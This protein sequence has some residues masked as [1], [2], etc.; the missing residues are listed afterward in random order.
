MTG[1]LVVLVS[2]VPEQD[3]AR[4]RAAAPDADVTFAARPADLADRIPGA[5]VVAGN[6]D[7]ASFGRASALRWVHSWAAG[8]DG[9]L[10]PELVASPVVLTSSKGNGAV[11][12]AEH[13]LM[14]ML[15]LDRDAPRWMRAQESRTWDRFG[16]GELNGATCGIV[17]MGG[18]GS[19]L[20][21]RAAAFDMRVLGLRRDS[22]RPVPGVERMYGPDE[23]ATFAA[24][25]DFLV[26]TAALTA[27]SRGLLGRAAFRAM[28]PT[29]FYVCVS[30]GGIADDPALLTALQEGW[31]AGAGLDAHDVEPLPADSPFWSLPNVIVT[32]HNGATTAQT[33]RRG[34]DVFV[35]N[36]GR[37]VRGEP[38]GNVVDKA[39]GY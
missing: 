30:R 19:A 36:L 2:G 9:A 34:V 22:A 13:A 21:R 27:Q 18:A 37:F 23:V 15:M 33:R 17:G 29:A 31:I 20:A 7:P 16:H 3:E 14:L 38:L 32:P 39:A 6:L 24:E 25:A 35:A 26:V 8:V 10:F 5:H 12:L 4:I 11:P 28:K 1:R